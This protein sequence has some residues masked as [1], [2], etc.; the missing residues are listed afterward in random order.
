MEGNNRSRE[1][2]V[3]M[4]ERRKQ[5]Y[6]PERLAQGSQA[7]TLLQADNVL[8]KG[9][10]YD[11]DSAWKSTATDSF[12]KPLVEGQQVERQ[13]SCGKDQRT[14]FTLGSEETTKRSTF[15]DDY[16]EKSVKQTRACIP[17]DFNEIHIA[18]M[19]PKYMENKSFGSSLYKSDYD[20]KNRWNQW[21]ATVGPKGLQVSPQERRKTT[22]YL[23]ATHFNLG[24][25]PASLSSET[26][27]SYSGLPVC[28][29][30]VS[31]SFAPDR[32][33]SHVF[34][35]GDYNAEGHP[36]TYVSTQKS[37]Y[38]EVPVAGMSTKT[39]VAYDHILPKQPALERGSRL[40]ALLQEQNCELF[41]NPRDPTNVALGKAFLKYDRDRS[42]FITFD[43]LK[44]MCND[45][46]KGPV[47]D[48]ELK[49]LL[50]E[51]DQNKDGKIDY[52]EFFQALNKHSKPVA[53][54]GAF[55]SVQKES[56]KE[57]AQDRQ[58]DE[59]ALKARRLHEDPVADGDY[60]IGTHFQ[61]GND[62]QATSSVYHQDFAK[63]KRQVVKPSKSSPLPPSQVMHE[64]PDWSFEATVSK[65]DYVD[66]R[67]NIKGASADVA[68]N[69]ERHTKQSVFL[70]CNP[71]NHKELRQQS[72]T[73]SSYQGRRGEGPAQPSIL[74][75]RYNHLRGD[76]ALAEPPPAASTSESH[77][78]YQ[79]PIS[80]VE[81]AAQ[82]RKDNLLER[83]Q[84]R[85][86]NKHTHFMFGFDPQAKLTEQQSA[87]QEQTVDPRIAA[88]GVTA[89]PRITY[90]H[91]LPSE[92]S[93]G[94][95]GVLGE[96]LKKKSYAKHVNPRDPTQI[97]MT[98]AFLDIDSDLS[99]K[100]TPDELAMVCKRYG[101]EIDPVSLDDLIKRCDRDGDGMIDYN[102]FVHAFSTQKSADGTFETIMRGDYKPLQQRTFTDMQKKVIAVDGRRNRPPQTTHFF[103]MNH[104]NKPPL[105][106][107]TQ[108][109]IKPE[110]M[111]KPKAA[112]L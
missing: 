53:V 31:V 60:Q 102:E 99:G 58:Q 45:L 83:K 33:T 50:Q 37:D 52:V 110:T 12:K 69:K 2:S 108:D 11:N 43:E 22:N 25:D 112:A 87:F 85:Q 6:G 41:Q 111:S 1:P 92:P 51:C 16:K 28:G 91:V 67:A 7:R 35:S 104:S 56:Y 34:R 46:V 40:K 23:R 98:A 14:N 39:S 94:T 78:E 105:S 61:F 62:G 8:R 32:S 21:T 64:D 103:H 86:D 106:T 95:A 47:S 55:L 101:I 4:L 5:L 42:G 90:S 66:H 63:I 68:G 59:T 38:R 80:S 29:G 77:S 3:A 9:E 74:S 97:K 73:Q 89:L 79:P 71:D 15:Q 109:F 30:P 20:G 36:G 19:A 84:R 93:D 81:V 57:A 44:A 26:M 96:E 88:A 27:S 107:T 72:L 54:E 18:D 24:S 17:S 49:D 76:D 100:I 82:R 65:S 48:E 75:D 70:S 13:R 10:L